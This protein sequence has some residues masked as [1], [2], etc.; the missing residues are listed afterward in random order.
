MVRGRP[1]RLL[2]V[3]GERGAEGAQ[4]RQT[5]FVSSSTRAVIRALAR[6]PHA[7]IHR[8][9]EYR[10]LILSH[11]PMVAIAARSVVGA[12]ITESIGRR[13]RYSVWLAQVAIRRAADD[14]SFFRARLCKA[15][16]RCISRRG[17]SS[18]Q[19]RQPLSDAPFGGGRIKGRMCILRRCSAKYITSFRYSGMMSVGEHGQAFVSDWSLPRVGD[20]ANDVYRW[21][22]HLALKLPEVVFHRSAMRVIA[23]RARIAEQKTATLR[24]SGSRREVTTHGAVCNRLHRSPSSR[25]LRRRRRRCTK[26]VE[27]KPRKL[28]ARCADECRFRNGSGPPIFGTWY[29]RRTCAPPPPSVP[30][31]K[32]ASRIGNA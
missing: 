11:I 25:P 16:G 23:H 26:S 30:P 32:K 18:S 21:P 2:F 22:G 9:F 28:H 14:F 17:E 4:R 24:K 20:D 19:L 7:Q 27:R 29:Q 5:A 1:G 12:Q 10:P 31:P 15:G 3:D 6:D 13:R 8:L